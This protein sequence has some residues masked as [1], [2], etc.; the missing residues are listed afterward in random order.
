[1]KFKTIKTDEEYESALTQVEMLLDAAPESRE[2][3]ELNLWSLLVEQ[4]EREH[5]PI[6]APDPIEAIKFRM[7]QLG[8]KQKDLTVY[9]SSKSKVS[10]VLNY[11]R[12]LSLTMIRN[13]NRHLGIPAEVL[14]KESPNRYKVAVKRD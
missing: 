12:P 4:Y 6:D 3:E 5:Y 1:M 7:D 14:V 9:F 10:E 11:K 13:L 2:E 8:L